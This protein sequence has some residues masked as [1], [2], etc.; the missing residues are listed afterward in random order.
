MLLETAQRL[1]V[2]DRK[3]DHIHELLHNLIERQADEKD[4]LRDVEERTEHMSAITDRL[5][6]SVVALTSAEDASNA[7]LGQLAQL[8]RDNVNDPVALAKIADD[9]DTGAAKLTQAVLEN[10]PAAPAP[11]EPPAD[12][13]APA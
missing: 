3:L 2:I 5:A 10:T 7:L 8:V 12:G 6:A 13:G 4:L 11:A 1:D 9:I